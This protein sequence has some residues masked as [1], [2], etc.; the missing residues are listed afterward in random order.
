M[1]KSF[2][3][4]LAVIFAI[5]MVLGMVPFMS[6]PVDA[7]SYKFLNTVFV[8]PSM[9]HETANLTSQVNSFV[10]EDFGAV[11]RRTSSYTVSTK[12]RF[13]SRWNSM[14]NN[15]YVVV[16]DS[17]GAPTSS[18]CGLTISDID[19]LQWKQIS[20]IVILGCNSGHYDWRTENVARTFAEK[21]HTTVIACDGNVGYGARPTSANPYIDYS[22]EPH[23]S[24][25]WEKYCSQ[26]R[27]S[28]RNMYGWLAYVPKSSAN[29]Y[30]GGLYQIGQR[31]R[32]MT[33]YEMLINY[34]RG[35]ITALPVK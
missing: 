7:A 6:E 35:N 28:R 30:Q 29:N 22:F 25:A 9:D 1:K 16:I 11:E 2:K 34:S 12:D 18:I 8:I 19:N 26:K 24:A 20:Y 4:L 27:P 32:S 21:F 5:T 15:Q 17:H 14:P 23:C 13:I 3:R 33:V 10:V 31:A